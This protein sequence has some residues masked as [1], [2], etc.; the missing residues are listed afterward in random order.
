MAAI[1]LM[2]LTW[3]SVDATYYTG[4]RV[5]KGALDEELTTVAIL[6]SQRLDAE[7]HLQLV[8]PEQQNGPEY[9]RVVAPLADA[10]RATPNLKYIYTLR[11]S[12]EG[13]RFVVDAA[14]PIDSDGAGV[15]DQSALAEL[16]EEP[17][18]GR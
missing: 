16:Y 2:V 13:P 11:E 14:E 17:D 12:P 8:T 3:F 1:G 4:S 10:L 5:L 15:I 6:A 7:A 18:P 9:K